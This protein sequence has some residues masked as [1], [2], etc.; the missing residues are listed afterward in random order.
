MARYGKEWVAFRDSDTRKRSPGTIFSF[1]EMDFGWRCPVAGF[2]TVDCR[3]AC[4][5]DATFDNVGM[6]RR[7]ST[8]DS[9]SL[10][11]GNGYAYE[12]R[13]I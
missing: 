4:D 7:R 6:V 8:S 12:Y 9:P 10:I 11:P 5:Y 1:I 3:G 2:L 13:L